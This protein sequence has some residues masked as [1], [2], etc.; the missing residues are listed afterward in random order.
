MSYHRSSVPFLL[1][2]KATLFP[3]ALP[4]LAFCPEK[5]PEHPTPPQNNVKVH[6]RSSLVALGSVAEFTQHRLLCVCER[7]RVCV[8]VCVRVC[9]CVC[10]LTLPVVRISCT[11]KLFY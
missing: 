11:L 3:H 7:V 4:A 10:V 5:P 9:V 1:C 2:P 8:C 6:G